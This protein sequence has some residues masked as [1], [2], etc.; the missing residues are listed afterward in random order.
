VHAPVRRQLFY[1]RYA[2]IGLSP[3]QVLPGALREPA[4]ACPDP[5]QLPLL[6][7]FKIQ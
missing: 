1:G 7:L 4:V 6:Q 3:P 5:V 2:G